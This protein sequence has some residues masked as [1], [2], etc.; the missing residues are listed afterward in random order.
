MQGSDGLKGID[1]LRALEAAQAQSA[2]TR[3]VGALDDW[4]DHP[5]TKQEEELRNAWVDLRERVY[6]KPLYGFLVVATDPS[7]HR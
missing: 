1:G 2:L 5:G 6:G 7:L 3:L 4:H